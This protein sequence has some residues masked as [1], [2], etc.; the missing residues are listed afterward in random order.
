MKEN[1]LWVLCR[2][3]REPSTCV[4]LQPPPLTPPKIQS[5]GHGPRT[6]SHPDLARF[7]SSLLE[8]VTMLP[9]VA[10]SAM[11][12]APAM[13]ALWNAARMFSTAPT[14]LKAVVAAKIPAE[15]V[16]AN[17]FFPGQQPVAF[18]P[19]PCTL[20]CINNA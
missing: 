17:A 10:Q 12:A 4:L 3:L 20:L 7:R 2:C 6:I 11:A 16:G 19:P 8:L 9:A 18:A 15:Q 1:L 14:D 5:H 13:G